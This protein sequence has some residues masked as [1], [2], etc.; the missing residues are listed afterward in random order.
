MATPSFT[1]IVLYY[2]DAG[3][4]LIFITPVINS[5]INLVPLNII[6]L[7]FFLFMEISYKQLIKLYFNITSEL[8]K[9]LS[10]DDE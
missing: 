3:I 6:S 7:I 4:S 5:D 2:N 10:D 1:Y 8:N 9:V